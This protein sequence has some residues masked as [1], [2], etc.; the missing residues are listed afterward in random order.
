MNQVVFSTTPKPTQT[1]TVPESVSRRDDSASLFASKAPYLQKTLG[2]KLYSGVFDW[3]INFGVNLFVSAAFTQYVTHSKVPIWKSV[4]FGGKWLKQSSIFN[5][6]PEV[7]YNHVRSG[8]GRGLKAISF[9]AFDPAPVAKVMADAL[10]LTT[11]GSV[12]MIPSVWLGAKCKA[13]FVNAV[14]TLWYGHGNEETA[15]WLGARHEHVATEPKATLAG[16]IIGRIGTIGAVQLTSATLGANANLIKKLGNSEGIRWMQKF[17][18]IDTISKTIGET[19]GYT[20]TKAA[21][22]LSAKFNRYANSIGFEFSADQLSQRTHLG[23]NPQYNT[24]LA[25]YTRYTALDTMY[26]FVTMGTIHPIINAVKKVIPGM[27]YRDA[28]KPETTVTNIH[29]HDRVQAS[30]SRGVSA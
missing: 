16:A 15:A 9:G 17:D 22:K 29:M 30:D 21:P 12:I 18:G 5:H 14:D 27:T 24:A 4:P 6:S 23:A 20:L 13:G 10:T 8:I 3:G 26:T 7:A 28:P 1:H 11:A 2:E 25:D 19:A